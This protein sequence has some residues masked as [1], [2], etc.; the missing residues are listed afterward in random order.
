MTDR[1]PLPA[2]LTGNLNAGSSRASCAPTFRLCHLVRELDGAADVQFHLSPLFPL[3][4][5]L[6]AFKTTASAA[7]FTAGI[8]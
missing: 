5:R 1:S 3:G 4:P 2:D 8:A 7:S 6:S